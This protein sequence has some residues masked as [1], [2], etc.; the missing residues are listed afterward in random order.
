[1]GTDMYAVMEYQDESRHWHLAA[2]LNPCERNYALQTML[3]RD[4]AA[5][6]IPP[7]V[8]RRGLPG[9][10]SDAVLA[11]YDPL[12]DS[13]HSILGEETQSWC[14]LAE[15]AAYDWQQA[16]PH[17]AD[18]FGDVDAAGAFLESCITDAARFGLPERTRLVFGFTN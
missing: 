5:S 18:L 8:P 1:M 16:R 14:T 2:N 17:A 15:V 3:G 12:A 10:L 11:C 4:G 9:D 6:L 7:V 13:Y